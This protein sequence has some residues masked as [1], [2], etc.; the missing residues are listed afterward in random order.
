MTGPEYR[1]RVNM[2]GFTLPVLTRGD[3]DVTL[4]PSFRNVARMQS[5]L[6]GIWNQ[7]VDING[8]YDDATVAAVKDSLE[9]YL[10]GTTGTIIGGRQWAIILGMIPLRSAGITHV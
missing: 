5:I 6:K 2:N 4:G 1:D 8:I 7:P 10:P 3:N 9:P